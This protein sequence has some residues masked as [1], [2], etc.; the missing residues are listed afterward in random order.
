[1][2]VLAVTLLLQA[3]HDPSGAIVV[4]ER[5]PQAAGKLQ[6]LDRMLKVL[7]DGGHKVLIF[8]QVCTHTCFFF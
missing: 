2:Y 5:L 8:C 1:M 7:K 6:L 3:P 4:D